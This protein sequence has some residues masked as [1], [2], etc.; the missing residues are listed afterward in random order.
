[1][2]SNSIQFNSIE[3]TWDAKWWKNFSKSSCEYG[4]EKKNL[5]KKQIQKNTFPHVAS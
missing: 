4:V 1:L 5:K 2:N 3:N